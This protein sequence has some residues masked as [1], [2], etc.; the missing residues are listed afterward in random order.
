MLPL[1]PIR[2]L[3]VNLSSREIR[4]EEINDVELIKK[5][6]GGRGLAAYLYLTRYDLT[7]DPFDERSPIFY[8]AGLLTGTSLPCSGRT[9]ILFKS[10]ATNRIFKTNVGGHFG[11]ELRA[12]GY[13]LVVV[14]GRAEHPVYIDICDDRVSIED[15][16]QYWGMDNRQL[17]NAIRSEKK[18]ERVQLAS[19][20]QAGENGVIF[21]SI[22]TS[23]YNA[24]GRGGGGAVMG[25]KNLKAIAVRG[26]R[27]VKVAQPERFISIADAL[28]EKACNNTGMHGLSMYG[29]SIGLALSNAAHTLPSY[30]FQA[31]HCDGA[32]NLSGPSIVESGLLERRV[33]CYSCPVGCHRY[34]VV[35]AGRFKGSYTVGPEYETL[36]A[37]GSGIGITDPNTVVKANEY[38]SLYGMDTI[39][40][41]HMIQWLI[42][43]RERGLITDEEAGVKLEW[44]N[45]ETVIELTR[46]IAMREGIGDLLA[47]GAK[48]ASEE[49]GGDSYKWAMQAKGLEQSRVET[50]SSYSYALAFAINSRGP[51]HLNTECLAER[52]GSEEAIRIIK[53]VTGSEKYAFPTCKEKR[54]E[55]VRWH[56]DIYALGDSSGICAFPTTA[57]H[58]MDEFDIAEALSA[59]LGF[60]LTADEVML[61]GRRTITLER[62]CCALLGY[63]RD[64]DVLPYR[65]MNEFRPSKRENSGDNSK[66]FLERMKDD[67]YRLHGWDNERGWPKK[68]TLEILGMG[69]L[70]PVVSKTITLP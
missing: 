13:D 47:K 39:S 33:G 19:I 70:I 27:G 42:E 2:I 38:C 36:S 24:A 50:R 55:I 7:L 29:T 14:E 17:N 51:D 18:D 65:M 9:S 1:V 56:E 6:C 60:E 28:W 45:D 44:G 41:G 20:G 57:Q 61:M 35:K 16:R 4:V 11:G 48:R 5:Y 63:T 59:A 30:N 67:Y 31:G 21:A 69:E 15:A 37:F 68:E 58:W 3:H 22:H 66:D 40:C 10:P 52:G 12:A 54:A 46:M 43:C 32:D 25:S 49:M 8:A 64:D 34:S 53:R 23:I 62:L 26:H